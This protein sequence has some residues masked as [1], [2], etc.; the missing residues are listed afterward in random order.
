V[1]LFEQILSLA[2]L[3]A[4]QL[5]DGEAGELLGPDASVERLSVDELKR[6]A[7]WRDYLES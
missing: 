7:A 4:D 6:S 3:L 1:T 2:A 5:D